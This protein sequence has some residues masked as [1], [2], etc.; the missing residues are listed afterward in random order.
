MLTPW[1]HQLDAVA[2]AEAH[3]YRTMYAMDMGTGKTLAALLAL[4]R[5]EAKRILVFC[6]KAVIPVWSREISQFWNPAIPIHVESLETRGTRESTQQKAKRAAQALRED[7]VR[8]IVVNYEA[9]IYDALKRLFLQNKWDAII[10]DESQKIKKP[11]GKA[12]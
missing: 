3:N 1:K 8:V 12:S 6:P 10:A 7:R 4:E 9:A 11:G 5:M 2:F